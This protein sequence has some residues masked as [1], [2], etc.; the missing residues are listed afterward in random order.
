VMVFLPLV[1]FLIIWILT[2]QRPATRGLRQAWLR[3]SVFFGVMLVILTEILSIFRLITPLGLGLTWGLLAGVGALLLLQVRFRHGSVRLPAVKIPVEW[4]ERGLLLLVLVIALVTA[5]IAWVAPPNTWDSLNYHMPRVAHWAQQRAVRH[6]I[7]GIEVQNS[8]PPAAEM[9]VLNVYVLSGGDR[10]VNFIS[11]FA[12]LGS[13]IGITYIASLLG[14]RSMGQVLAGVLAATLPMGIA[15]ASSTMTDYVVALWMVTLFSETLTFNRKPNQDDAIVFGSLAAGLGFLTKPTATAYLLPFVLMFVVIALRSRPLRVVLQNATVAGALFL[16]VNAGHLIRNLN[17]Y[18]NPIANPERISIHATDIK[19]VRLFVSNVIRNVG[20]HLGTPSP[21]V[22]KAIYLVVEK[23][24][25]FIGIPM[26]DPRITLGGAFKVPIPSTSESKATNP[27]HAYL[28]LLVLGFVLVRFKKIPSRVFASIACVVAGFLV[29]SFFFQW[30]IFAARLHLS[31]FVLAAGIIGY[32]LEKMFPRR[33]NQLIGLFLCIACL[34][35]L[36]SLRSRPLLTNSKTY[37][38]SILETPRIKL[39]YANGGH[40]L[41]PHEEMIER[42]DEADCLNVGII[43]PGNGAEYPLW[44]LSGA[45][46]FGPRFEWVINGGPS[47]ELADDA[48]SPCAVIYRPNVSGATRFFELPLAYDH[49]PTQ[50]S[51]F[52]ESR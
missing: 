24:H 8:M 39:Y 18:G 23:I 29:Y 10:W 27:A 43:L 6:Y 41:E 11:W 21:H 51:L 47:V 45:P 31:F 17:L 49:R 32:G 33:L 28:F 13:V 37:Y 2:L 46:R 48:F 22:N 35:W 36:L 52:M 19:D 16:L 40:L 12:M 15:Q 34:P 4:G 50:Y 25:E 7:T 42:I 20:I 14:A 30:Q 1:V 5:L 38:R 3:A 26:D 44:V 9:A